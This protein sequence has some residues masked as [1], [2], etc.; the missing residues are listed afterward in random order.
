MPTDTRKRKSILAVLLFSVGLLLIGLSAAVV[1]QIDPWTE[2]LTGL[3]WKHGHLMLMGLW[4]LAACLENALLCW[5]YFDQSKDRVRQILCLLIWSLLFGGCLIPWS[6]T[7][8]AG[9]LHSLL[10]TAA[11][12]LW[13]GLWAYSLIDWTCSFSQKKTAAAVLSAAAVCISF[14]GLSGGV[15]LVSEFLFVLLNAGILSVEL[16]R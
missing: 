3:G 1:Q 5:L 4:A 12:G 6:E 10:C 11:V 7:G 9:D 15:S 14:L 16:L 8:Y 13:I 2:N